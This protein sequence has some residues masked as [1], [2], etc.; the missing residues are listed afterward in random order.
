MDFN[1]NSN[2]KKK[3]QNNKMCTWSLTKK[4]EKDLYAINVSVSIVHKN[5]KK[6]KKYK[7]LFKN[8]IRKKKTKCDL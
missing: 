2:L 5:I 6:K 7:Y 3:L 1:F 4:E 8:Q